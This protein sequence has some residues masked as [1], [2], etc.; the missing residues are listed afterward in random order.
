MRLRFRRQG[1]SWIKGLALSITGRDGGEQ[2]YF[3]RDVK[4]QVTARASWL[5]A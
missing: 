5:H 1:E 2:S 3:H 4:I